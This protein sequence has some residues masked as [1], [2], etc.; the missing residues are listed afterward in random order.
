[1]NELNTISFKDENLKVMIIDDDEFQ[2]DFVVDQLAELGVS[3]VVTANSGASALTTF[4]KTQ[5]KPD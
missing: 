1:M 5:P 4:D 2:I 3:Q